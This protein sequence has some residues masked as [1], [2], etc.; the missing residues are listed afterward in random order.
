L[1]IPL[2]DPTI[3]TTTQM[4]NTGANRGGRGRGTRGGRGSP[5]PSSSSQSPHRGASPRARGGNRPPRSRGYRGRGGPNPDRPQTSNEIFLDGEPA[6]PANYLTNEDPSHSDLIQAFSSIPH[7]PARPVR[8][9]YGTTGESGVIRAN[10]FELKSLPSGPIYD[11]EIK[12]QP[13][14]KKRERFRLFQLL[15]TAPEYLQYASSAAHDGSQ[16]LV[17]LSLLPQPLSCNIPLQFEDEGE[18]RPSATTFAISITQTAELDLA[19]MKK[20]LPGD[21]AAKDYNIAPVVSAFNL[22]LQRHARETGVPVGKGS[23][24]RYF[25]P[26]NGGLEKRDLGKGIEALRGFFLSVRPS[27]TRLLVNVDACVSAFVKPGNL[28]DALLQFQR[29]SKGAMPG[30]VVPPKGYLG[31]NI[32]VGLIHLGYSK[33]VFAIGPKPPST[34]MFTLEG[35]Q[36]SVEDYFAD[37]HD[38][39]LKYPQELPVVNVGSKRKPI[40][41]PPELCEILPGTVY[42]GE[43]DLQGIRA[44]L[45]FATNPPAHNAK[46]IVNQGFETLDL[47][48]NAFN[49]EVDNAMAVVPYR[50]LPAPSVSYPEG[51]G[52]QRQTNTPSDASWNLLSGVKFHR[53]VTVEKWW[54]ISVREAKA[55]LLEGRDDDPSRENGLIP[56]FKA[57]LSVLGVTIQDCSGFLEVQLNDWDNDDEGRTGSIAKIR[58]RIDEGISTLGK[59]DFILVLLDARDNFIY[60]AIKRIGDVDL[61]IHTFHMQLFPALGGKFKAAKSQ[62]QYL[63]NVALKVNIK[64][65]GVNHILTAGATNWL[66]AKPTMLVGIDV[67]HRSPGSREGTPSVAAVVASYDDDFVQFPASIKLQTTGEGERPK[68][69]VDHLEEMLKERLA[70]YKK[71]N[72]GKLPERI[73]I[74]RDGVSEGQFNAVLEEELKDIR[75]AFATFNKGEDRYDPALTVII[76][77]KRHHAKMWPTNSDEATKNGNTRPGSVIDKGITAVYD[78]DFYLQ[79]HAPIQGHAKGTHYTVVYDSARFTADDIQNGTHNFSYLYA[80]ATKAVSLVPPA[81]YADLACERARMY[82]HNFFVDDGASTSGDSVATGEAGSSQQMDPKEKKKQEM[83]AVFEAAVTRWENGLHPDL[84]E[85]M[86]YI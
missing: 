46:S 20:Y 55:G 31:S 81:Y 59:P 65:G 43:F 49:I 74:F 85:S 11:Y 84:R 17:S 79:A 21:I 19:E 82:L 5:S 71:K 1:P 45:G 41:V 56:K 52:G 80:R 51:S 18:A 4:S 63:A 8:P 86:F 72:E 36:K 47:T 9:G 66:T 6:T 69:M 64:L 7:D 22:F 78:F 53:P 2:I 10:F 26:Q 62:D 14:P 61:G 44:M 50:L 27:F 25:F 33:T 73:I 32:R 24:T 68:E 3:F 70:L 40:W 76:C 30:R 12:F 16:R 54:V 28:A 37:K 67:T 58:K 39:K 15:E 75:K 13:E 83:E 48:S 57:K 60:P 38:I 35:N 23:F 29:K 34:M 77:G 42:R